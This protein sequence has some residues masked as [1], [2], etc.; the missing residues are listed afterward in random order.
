MSDKIDLLPCPFCGQQ[1]A[2]VEQL[3][4]DASVVICQGRIDKYSACLARGPVGVQE[5]DTEDQPGKDA[6]IREWNRRAA[7]SQQAAPVVPDG[8]VLVT[9][10]QLEKHTTTAWECPPQSLVVL[11]SS[12]KRLHDK[13]A[14]VPPATV[15]AGAHCACGDIYPV[16]S[17]GAGFI[18]GSGMCPNCDAAIPAQDIA[19][20]VAQ[21]TLEEALRAFTADDGR[22]AFEAM[23]R[24]QHRDIT[25]D[26]R[27]DPPLA[28]GY[29]NS[30]THDRWCGWASACRCLRGALL[31]DAPNTTEGE[32]P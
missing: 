25:R 21:A 31:A 16:G 9:L 32:R 1:D 12:L 29:A 15:L 19:A 14:A 13:N 23:C 5:S 6:A 7:L 26:D 28:W 3:D 30:L 24:E 2:L 10:E 8:Y 20:S 4:S 18:D 22:G 17:Y 11:A 27:P